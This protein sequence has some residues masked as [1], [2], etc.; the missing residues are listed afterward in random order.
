MQHSDP[1]GERGLAARIKVALLREA[2]NR[3]LVTPQ[4]FSQIMD[5]RRDG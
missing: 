2:L 4:Q 3:R 5:L 1:G